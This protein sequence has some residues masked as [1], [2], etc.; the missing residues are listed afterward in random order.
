MECLVA[1]DI[2]TSYVKAALINNS[3]HVLAFNSERIPIHRT[4]Q[5]SAEHCPKELL[6]ICKRLIKKVSSNNKKLIR[7]IVPTGYQFGLLLLDKYDNPINGISTL[8]DTRAHLTF[9]DFIDTFNIDWIY[10]TTGCPAIFHYPLARLFYFKRNHPDIFGRI[11]KILSAK[12]YLFLNLTGQWLSDASTSSATQL[13]SLTKQEWN[14]EVLTKIGIDKDFLPSLVSSYKE[15]YPLK[16]EVRREL[17]L[18]QDVKV[19]VGLYDSAALA[20][21]MNALKQGQG[22]CNLGTSAMLR[23]V[24]DNPLLDQKEKKLQA[25]HFIDGS[26]LIGSGMNNGLIPLFW[27]NQITSGKSTDNSLEEISKI[28]PGADGLLCL[29]YFTGERDPELGEQARGVLFGLKETHASAHIGK[30]MLE[31]VTFHL[32]SVKQKL[33]SLGITLGSIS[34]GGGGSQ[35]QALIQMMADIF[36]IPLLVSDS[37]EPALIGNAIIGFANLNGCS[38][39]DSA[40]NISPRLKIIHP[41]IQNSIKYERISATYQELAL[42]SS[43][44]FPKLAE[45]SNS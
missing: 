24:S 23:S 29:P 44:L 5:F 14:Q 20:I 34:M 42:I 30:A 13:M 17:D 10:Q 8:L 12:D 40:N 37:G 15:S 33:S 28:T 41:I 1:L 18:N 6:D 16:E 2:G 39:Q 45:F 32:N 21:G 19:L 22:F 4:T 11:T 36:N 9:H 7:A 25:Y 3:G 38:V 27:L 26:Y 31:G 35:N 43:S